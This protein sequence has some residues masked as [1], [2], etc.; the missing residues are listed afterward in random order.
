MSYFRIFIY[1][2][3]NV[4]HVHGDLESFVDHLEIDSQY[5]ALKASFEAGWKAAI[6]EIRDDITKI[7]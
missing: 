7:K 3:F 4:E 1:K 5:E 6:N 2:F